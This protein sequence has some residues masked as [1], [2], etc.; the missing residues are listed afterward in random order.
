MVIPSGKT[1]ALYLILTTASEALAAILTVFRLYFRYSIG[2]LW[3][4]DFWA[5]LTLL[6]NS[7]SIIGS[8]LLATPLDNPYLAIFGLDTAPQSR[9]THIVSFWLAILFY[10][11]TIWFARFSIISSLI[12]IVPPTR[13]VRLATLGSAFVLALMGIFVLLAKALAC[14]IGASW[15]N[16]PPF[17]CPIPEWVAISEAITDSLS[18]SSILHTSSHLLLQEK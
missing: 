15:Y 6:C 3:W 18:A 16:Q 5:A 7:I 1:V 13:S 4:D 12:R 2:R 14:S 17:Q 9:N 8:W 11:C 10:T